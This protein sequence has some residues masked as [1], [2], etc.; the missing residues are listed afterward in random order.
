MKHK[1]SKAS[2]F[3]VA[4]IFCI[5]AHLRICSCLSTEILK[6]RVFI[7]ISNL[8]GGSNSKNGLILGLKF[9]VHKGYTG[10][11]LPI[12]CK[13]NR[14]VQ[15]SFKLHG[16]FE[17]NIFSRR[18][19]H[20][21]LPLPTSCFDSSKVDE[22]RFCCGTFLQAS[23]PANEESHNRRLPLLTLKTWRRWLRLMFPVKS[24]GS[25]ACPEGGRCKC[26]RGLNQF[27]LNASVFSQLKG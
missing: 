7:Y 11:N 24:A 2:D 10:M 23:S 8:S 17:N 27:G 3:I 19:H 22:S 5:L 15:G 18:N 20:F 4:I 12:S 21:K 9:W 26:L 13:L 16:G 25:D 6:K 1:H 14:M